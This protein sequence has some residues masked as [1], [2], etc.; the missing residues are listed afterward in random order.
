MQEMKGENEGEPQVQTA[1]SQECAT[2]WPLLFHK[3]EVVTLGGG[4]GLQLGFLLPVSCLWGSQLS[5]LPKTLFLLP[6]PAPP[7][8][9]SRQVLA[10]PP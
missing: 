10:P 6:S 9:S 4:G 1:P 5:L 7:L 2:A 8:S 3:K